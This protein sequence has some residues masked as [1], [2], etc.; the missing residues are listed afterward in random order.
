MTIEYIYT[1]VNWKSLFFRTLKNFVDTIIK[2]YKKKYFIVINY[3]LALSSSISFG[4]TSKAS[5]TTP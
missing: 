5:P 3:T 1:S 4:I 2:N